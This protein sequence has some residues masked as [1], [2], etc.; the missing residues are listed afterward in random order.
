MKKNVLILLFLT[1]LIMI[2]GE[3]IPV[4]KSN[5]EVYF[6]NESDCLD[7]SLHNLNFALNL[8]KTEFTDIDKNSIG[9]FPVLFGIIT[10]YIFVI[11]CLLTL[12]FLIVSYIH[13]K[14]I[15]SE[16]NIFN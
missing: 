7:Y 10:N 4:L 12:S 11:L 1:M 14:F 6:C 9:V 2:S 8:N 13:S 3:L 15:K 5:N 16:N